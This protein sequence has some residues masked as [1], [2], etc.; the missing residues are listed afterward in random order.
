MQFLLKILQGGISNLLQQAEKIKRVKNENAFYYFMTEI[1]QN[2]DVAR[3]FRK[4]SYISISSFVSILG[5]LTYLS[6]F[7]PNFISERKLIPDIN[8]DSI[9]EK[10][11][12]YNSGAKD[13]LFSKVVADFEGSLVDT[14]YSK[15]YSSDSTDIKVPLLTPFILEP[16]TKDYLNDVTHKISYQFGDSSK[17]SVLKGPYYQNNYK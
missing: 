15:S 16:R 12:I 3:K 2:D 10:L 6:F 13:T 14:V 17:R 9:K 8:G 11:I 7:N 5:F 1:Y 4:I